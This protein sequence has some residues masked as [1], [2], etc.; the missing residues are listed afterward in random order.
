ML[1]ASLRFLFAP[2]LSA[3]VVTMGVAGCSGSS[4]SEPLSAGALAAGDAC[5]CEA[6]PSS[7]E[8]AEALEGTYDGARCECG[9]QWGAAQEAF[10]ACWQAPVQCEPSRVQWIE[11]TSYST[12]GASARCLLAALRDR[13][14]GTYAHVTED[15]FSNGTTSGRHHFVI[16]ADGSVAYSLLQSAD[17]RVDEGEISERR[18]HP[19][20]TCALAGPEYFTGCLTALDSG[21]RTAAGCLFAE[22]RLEEWFA[23]CSESASACG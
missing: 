23:G 10:D 11:R 7:S 13:T 20:L 9:G 14:P 1:A 18:S 8:P 5:Q 19:I 2:L 4:G 15:A 17:L 3:S 12:E 21:E 16:A 6:L 22:E